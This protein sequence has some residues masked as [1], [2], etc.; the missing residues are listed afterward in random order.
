MVEDSRRHHDHQTLILL[1][2]DFRSASAII[3]L[4]RE[5]ITL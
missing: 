5:A 2:S 1:D 3:A 4:F